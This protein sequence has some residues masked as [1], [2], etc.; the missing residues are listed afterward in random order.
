MQNPGARSGVVLSRFNAPNL[1]QFCNS[2]RKLDQF[3][4][5]GPKSS[6]GSSI[7]GI[8]ILIVFGS[9][10]EADALIMHH[11]LWERDHQSHHDDLDHD[12]RHGA[13]VN[14]AGRDRVHKLAGDAIDVGLFWR[15]RAQ[16]E[17]CEP[18]RRMHERGLHVHAED[19]AKPDQVDAEFISLQA[20]VAG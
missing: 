13:P 4:G 2:D 1:S 19:H 6:G 15:H 17:Q 16:I 12:E 8:S 18:E 7:C 14:L 11:H 9:T 3:F 5:G 10:V 20:R